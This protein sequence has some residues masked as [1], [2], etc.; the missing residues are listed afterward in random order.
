MYYVDTVP[1]Q[2]YF[3][4]TQSESLVL[5]IPNS[6]F[7]VTSLVQTKTGIK[8]SIP[9][10]IFFLILIK[11]YLFSDTTIIIMCPYSVIAFELFTC[12]FLVN[13][14]RSSVSVSYRFFPGDTIYTN[15]FNLSKEYVFNPL[16][17]YLGP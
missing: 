9:F 16:V 4:Y 7:M 10:S 2:Y 11:I 8:Q 15:S 3:K 13:S 12:N 6:P 14:S 1:Y 5:L 17:R